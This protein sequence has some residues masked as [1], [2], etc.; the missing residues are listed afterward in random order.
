MR[1]AQVAPLIESVPPEA[2]GGTERVVSY[3]TEELVRRGHEVT[4]FASGDSSTRARL[5]STCPRALRSDANCRDPFA[6]QIVLLEHVYRM[7]REFDLVHFHVD[8]VHFPMSRR[9]RLPRLTTLHGRLDAPELQDLC[10]VFM[11]EPLVS[12]SRSQQDPL[13]DAHWLGTV[14]HGLPEEQFQFH[15]GPGNYLAF[16]GRVSPEKRLDRAI[17]IA[18]KTGMPLRVAAKIDRADQAYYETEIRPLL[19]AAQSLVEFVGEIGEEQKSEFLGNAAALLFPIDWPEPFGLVMIESLACGTPVI[20]YRN[21]SVPEIIDD[22]VTGWIVD[23]M[24]DA[25]A[26][27]RRIHQLSRATCRMEFERRFSVRRMVDDYLV[28][29]HQVCQPFRPRLWDRLMKG[30]NGKVAGHW[31]SPV[32]TP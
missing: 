20:A 21:G 5:V 19:T 13:A 17:H 25:V 31:P 8:Y 15:E 32:S 3:L 11:D 27:V 6:R 2:Y 23:N 12:I 14:Y 29:Y 1:I 9:Q 22:G 28:I 10:R 7:S 26:A 18:M 16:L 4:L 30:R 24:A